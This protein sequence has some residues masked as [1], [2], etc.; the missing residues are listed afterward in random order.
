LIHPVFHVSQLKRRTGKGKVIAP[1]LPMLGPGSQFKVM[2]E[3]MLD[4][5]IIKR[6]KKAL[7]QVLIKWSNLDE[8]EATWED[9]S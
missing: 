1:A 4:R 6:R 8:L 2:P 5:R 3:K 9:Y 7:A